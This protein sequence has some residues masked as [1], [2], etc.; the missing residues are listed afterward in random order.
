MGPHSCLAPKW[1][2]YENHGKA[3]SSR[4]MQPRLL[5]RQT[6]DCFIRYKTPIRFLLGLI[7]VWLGFLAQQSFA[8]K[9]GTQGL[10]RI[11]AATSLL[12]LIIPPQPITTPERTE[13]QPE[14]ASGW[15]RSIGLAGLLVSALLFSKSF[16]A[17]YAL[18]RYEIPDRSPWE[19]F[20]FGVLTLI[21]GACF[22]TVG[23]ARARRITLW[24]GL[25]LGGIIGLAL[26]LR[27][28]LLSEM[29]YGLWSDRGLEWLGSTANAP[30]AR[31]SSD[32]CELCYPH[33]RASLVAVQNGSELVW[34]DQSTGVA[35]DERGFWCRHSLSRLSGRQLAA[36]TQFLAS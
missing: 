29:P 1:C 15:R 34:R 20:A 25:V 12:L 8:E 33:D 27:L 16:H 19:Y 22:L 14:I 7:G 4:F 35:R 5:A 17:F 28:H 2:P 13:N 10:I 18:E 9:S 3:R 23:L 21:F 24:Q 11:I 32:F 30:P 31:L 26:F 6:V 36:R